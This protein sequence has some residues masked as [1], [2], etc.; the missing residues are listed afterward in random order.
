[1]TLKIYLTYKRKYSLLSCAKYPL[2]FTYWVSVYY[3]HSGA[4][5]D[6]ETITLDIIRRKE[7]EV[8]CTLA[9]KAFTWKQGASLLLTFPVLMQVM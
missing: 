1:M 4:Q 2:W 7:P 3:R 6:G 8:N 9:I 5:P